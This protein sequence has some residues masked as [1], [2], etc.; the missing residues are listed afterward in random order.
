MTYISKIINPAIL[1]THKKN[2]AEAW[3]LKIDYNL[4]RLFSR[5]FRLG[6]CRFRTRFSI[7]RRFLDLA[8]FQTG[9]AYTDFFHRPV[10]IRAHCLQIRIKFPVNHIMRMGYR[11]P[12]DRFLAAYFTYFCH[13]FFL[14]FFKTIIIN[15]IGQ[16]ARF[17]M[18]Y[19]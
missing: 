14:Q 13:I 4:I 18:L 3:F 5:C 6:R 8:R 11:M 7:L 15:K 2:H 19:F 12:K 1:S 9:G 17:I 10:N 16:K